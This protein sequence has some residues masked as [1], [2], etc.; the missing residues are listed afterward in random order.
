MP[1]MQKTF[2]GVTTLVVLARCITRTVENNSVTWKKWSVLN[3]SFKMDKIFS[4]EDIDE[5]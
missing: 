2:F 3:R 4:N 1:T 5:L